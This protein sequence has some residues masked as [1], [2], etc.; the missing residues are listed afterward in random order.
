MPAK[1]KPV[2]SSRKLTLK[3][4]F[5]ADKLNKILE[6]ANW[7]DSDPRTVEDMSAAEF[8]L[9]CDEIRETAPNFVEEIVDG[10]EDACANDWL[11]D[12]GGKE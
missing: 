5:N 12:W 11:A 6:Y 10:S 1:K 9:F 8:K 2:K 4:E 3:L 7:G